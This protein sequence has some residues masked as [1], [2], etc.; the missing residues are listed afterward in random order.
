MKHTPTKKTA[1]AHGTSHDTAAATPTET[2]IG[3]PDT[4]ATATESAAANA[5]A[6]PPPST[7][8][9]PA[10]GASLVFIALPPANANIPSAPKG[11]TNRSGEDYRGSLPKKAE[12]AA[13]TGALADL[14]RFT[15]YAQVLGA[16]APPL[17]HVVQ[18]LQ[19]GAAWS[20][21]RVSTAMWEVFSQAQEGLA[22]V[23]IREVIGTLRPSFDL[24]V[25][26]NRSL[27]TRLPSL[28]SLLDAQ[29]VIARKSASTRRANKKADAEGNLPTHGKV[30]KARERAA[31]KAAL[32]AQSATAPS[33][34]SEAPAPTPAT[35]S[36]AAAPPAAT[37]P[38]PYASV[39]GGG[40]NN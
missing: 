14:K 24:A 16:T 5:S 35:P 8:A 38:R 9:P 36:A 30:G 39:G 15:D 19:A 3:A 28:A 29:K 34:P 21:M 4:D 11:W 2:P 12:L 25:T 23:A 1:A 26:A 13:L 40:A 17:E 33:A 6:A 18:L 22:W 10:S 7:P 37:T 31:G 20:S 27:A 32:A